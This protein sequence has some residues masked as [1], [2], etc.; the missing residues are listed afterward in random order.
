M[1]KNELEKLEQELTETLGETEL[2]LL[3]DILLVS[4]S[5]KER[6]ERLLTLLNKT[7]EGSNDST[8][9]H[10][11][12]LTKQIKDL[13]DTFIKHK[14]ILP[15]EVLVRVN[16]KV[17]ISNLADIKIPQAKE[18]TVNV[19]DE[20]R[21]K[22]LADIKFPEQKD[23]PDEIKVSNIKDIPQPGSRVKASS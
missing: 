1:D 13:Q 5:Q 21:V 4:K 6:S 14:L 22:N 7:L 3:R 18:V 10:F 9:E 17:E 12:T 23:F 19:P 16:D 2:E 8:A 20:V 15:D 11:S